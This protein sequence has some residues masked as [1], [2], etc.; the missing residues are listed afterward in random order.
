MLKTKKTTLATP[1]FFDFKSFF[2]PNSSR[3]EHITKFYRRKLKK[4]ENQS[5][6]EVKKWRCLSSFNLRL[7]AL[8]SE[9]TV[10]QQ[11][12]ALVCYVSVPLI[13][14]IAKRT[15]ILIFD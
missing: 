8:I 13:S 6:T 5:K 3:F 12:L 9:V 15:K 10:E 11:I 14:K 4:I 7:K 1:T 2:F